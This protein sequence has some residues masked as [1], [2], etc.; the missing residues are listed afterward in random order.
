MT[1]VKVMTSE[2]IQQE[3]K[4][5]Q[6]KDLKAL[7]NTIVQLKQLEGL[8]IDLLGSWLWIGGNTKKN[9][10]ALKAL[11]CRWASKKNSGI[12][13]AK[14]KPEGITRNQSLLKRLKLNMASK[15]YPVLVKTMQVKGC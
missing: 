10:E 6:E 11:G 13:I 15:Q 12:G 5:Q 14:A 4:A 1:D 3:A 9:K 2:E 7:M 8:N